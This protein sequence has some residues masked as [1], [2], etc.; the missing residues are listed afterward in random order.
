MDIEQRVQTL[1]EAG[2][3]RVGYDPRLQCYY[4]KGTFQKLVVTAYLKEEDV[5]FELTS[6]RD[7]EA[8]VLE[9]LLRDATVVIRDS[10]KQEEDEKLGFGVVR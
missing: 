8:M 3:T 7:G 9:K 6:H 4:A 5:D 1:L 10:L 2:I